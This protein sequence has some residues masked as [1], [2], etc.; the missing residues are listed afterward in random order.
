MKRLGDKIK[1]GR[2]K[3][4]MKQIDL[5][6][7]LGVHFT[8]ISHWELGRREPRISTVK[9]ICAILNIDEGALLK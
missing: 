6:K 8:Q 2:L 5:A 9:K 4:K 7:K 3:A 1:T